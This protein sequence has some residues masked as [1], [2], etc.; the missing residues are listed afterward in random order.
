MNESL[1][2]MFEDVKKHV[3]KKPYKYCFFGFLILL[4]I[5]FFTWVVYYIGDCGAVLVKTS[6]DVGD[7]LVFDGSLLAFIGTVVLGLLACWQNKKA[8]NLNEKL[9]KENLITNNKTNIQVIKLDIPFDIS[10]VNAKEMQKHNDLLAISE[11]KD[12]SGMY[13]CFNFRLSFKSDVPIY[14]I[15]ARIDEVI[16]Y[17]T[18]VTSDEVGS[19]EHSGYC[20]TE[21]I[22]GGYCD[23]IH[24]FNI[25][26]NI[27]KKFC[28]V[29]CLES[30]ISVVDFLC[31]IDFI[32]TENDF[33]RLIDSDNNVI[34]YSTANYQNL[35]GEIFQGE[36]IAVFIKTE[37]VNNFNI[38]TK[39]NF[40]FRFH[41]TGS[42]IMQKDKLFIPKKYEYYD[43]NGQSK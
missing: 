5:P 16:I 12:V 6:L 31:L 38:I 28:G 19:D 22:S 33:F 35:K 4:I 32:A 2:K 26:S 23:E 39:G 8:T 40:E 25:N 14:V 41:I 21:G 10:C 29:E 7:A 15:N 43:E 30:G 20:L 34:K 17:Y 13:N 36:R 11:A 1:K 18:Y 9:Q 37:L 27:E 24:F 3:T 42:K